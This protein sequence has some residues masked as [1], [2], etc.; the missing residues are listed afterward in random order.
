MNAASVHNVSLQF[1]SKKHAVLSDGVDKIYFMDRQTN[2]WQ[3]LYTINY[4]K[5][6]TLLY[7]ICDDQLQNCHCCLVQFN[8]QGSR[9]ETKVQWI[10]IEIATDVIHSCNYNVL[11]QISGQCVPLYSAICPISKKFILIHEKKLT[12]EQQEISNNDKADVACNSEQNSSI[13]YEN[14]NSEYSWTQNS[15][16]VVVNFSIPY[17]VKSRDVVFSLT[18]KD[19]SLGLM[20]GL[21]LIRGKLHG[22]VDVEGCTWILQDNGT[23]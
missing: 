6:C 1:P 20:D 19:I 23:R 12:I 5:P 22:Q 10:E 4:E 14:L 21:V 17:P 15:D 13:S 3:V 18:S 8:H 2:K 7:A 11:T 16:T 9:A